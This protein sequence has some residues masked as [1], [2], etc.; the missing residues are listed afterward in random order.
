MGNFV[1]KI[2]EDKDLSI[3]ARVELKKLFT[4]KKVRHEV[5]INNILFP[6]QFYSYIDSLIMIVLPPSLGFADCQCHRDE[7]ICESRKGRDGE[8]EVG[9]ESGQ[10]QQRRDEEGRPC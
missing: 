8:K 4:N 9:L 7:L 5:D 1:K 6:C 3:M 2:G 10:V